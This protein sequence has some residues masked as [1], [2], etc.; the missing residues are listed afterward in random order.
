MSAYATCITA[1]NRTGLCPLGSCLHPFPRCASP[2]NL[3][4]QRSRGISSWLA[5][6]R[7]VSVSTHR[8]ALAALLFFYGKV[9]C[10]DLPWLQEIGR[11]RPSRRLPVVLTPDEVV[12]ILGFLEGEHR[13]FAQLLYGTGMRISE[14]CNCGSRIWI[15]ITA[16]SSCGRAR[17]PR[18]GP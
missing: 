12:R 17:A 4:Q 16:R 10:T 6:E 11:P 3:G 14:V 8:Q 15:S 18:I 5:N 13:L 1:T 7:K 2:G 9:L